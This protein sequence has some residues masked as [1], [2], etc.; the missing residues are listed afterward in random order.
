VNVSF[1]CIDLRDAVESV[2]KANKTLPEVSKKTGEKICEKSI[3]NA[4]RSLPW[5]WT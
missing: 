1:R 2:V 3:F 5:N 4:L